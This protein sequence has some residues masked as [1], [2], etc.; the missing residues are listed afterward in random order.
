MEQY[1][2]LFAMDGNVRSTALNDRV[3]WGSDVLLFFVFWV[4]LRMLRLDRLLK[5]V[6]AVLL[7]TFI[8]VR[9]RTVSFPKFAFGTDSCEGVRRF[10]DEHGA[11][12]PGTCGS[13]TVFMKSLPTSSITT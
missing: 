11:G 4:G 1:V 13:R 7:V 9:I 5:D 8:P 2:G 10:E 12:N 3:W 6:S